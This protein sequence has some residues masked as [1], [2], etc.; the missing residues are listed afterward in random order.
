MPPI[1]P[2]RAPKKT[3]VHLR[4]RIARGTRGFYEELAPNCADAIPIHS[5]AAELYKE[6]D[7]IA[8]IAK[9]WLLWRRLQNAAAAA[10]LIGV[11]ESEVYNA[12]YRDVVQEAGG[13]SLSTDDFA[14]GESASKREAPRTAGGL[15]RRSISWICTARRLLW[16]YCRTFAAARPTDLNSR[17]GHRAARPANGRIRIK[18]GV[19]DERYM[20]S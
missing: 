11:S 19:R 18:T 4:S 12:M 16:R 7:E 14:C 3:S 5:A 15:R 8:E 10:P 6:C 17:L 13:P 9:A 1:A 20:H 2:G